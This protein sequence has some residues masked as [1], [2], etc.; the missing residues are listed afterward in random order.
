MG[1]PTF[2][3]MLEQERR[4]YR[5]N[6]RPT[7]HS[8][9]QPGRTLARAIA[10]KEY[11]DQRSRRYT[12]YEALHLSSEN[13]VVRRWS[14]TAF[15]VDDRSPS[16]AL[17][18]TPQN[19]LDTGGS[20]SPPV[21]APSS[22]AV[23]DTERGTPF[24]R[25]VPLIVEV[26]VADI[27]QFEDGLTIFR[28][29]IVDPSVPGF[30][31]RGQTIVLVG[32]TQQVARLAKNHGSVL[33][34]PLCSVLECV[35]EDDLAPITILLAANAS[36]HP[37]FE[38]EMDRDP[39]LTDIIEKNIPWRVLAD[40][41]AVSPIGGLYHLI[42]P[43]K[44][45]QY[46]VQN[47][48]YIFRST[49]VLPQCLHVRI[50]LTWDIGWRSSC[51]DYCIQQELSL[52]ARITG[53]TCSESPPFFLVS[54]QRGHCPENMIHGLVAKCDEVKIKVAYAIILTVVGAA[55]RRRDWESAERAAP[56]VAGLDRVT[57]DVAQRS[58]VRGGGP[59]YTG[60]EFQVL[61]KIGIISTLS[62]GVPFGMAGAEATGDLLVT[63]GRQ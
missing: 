30:L 16:P 54:F 52:S 29:A 55:K 53:K 19:L 38:V 7:S 50:L 42:S 32:M 24:Q 58:S 63:G 35:P 27:V 13:G 47:G 2:C 34:R 25:D 48:H 10:K 46:A 59:P 43:F 9:S 61:A 4:S 57:G 51:A 12:R 26:V 6:R 41:I 44:I 36:V 1:R 60:T 23:V 45:F 11:D 62:G 14:G 22:N 31:R 21:S 28:Y 15:T 56:R 39:S 40:T 8:L 3:T 20:V 33:D 17:E 18:R 5:K 37:S 49:T